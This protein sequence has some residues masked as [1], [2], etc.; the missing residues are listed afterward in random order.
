MNTTTYLYILVFPQK[1]VIK[2][3][4]ANDIQNRIDSLRRWWGEVNY[5]ASYYLSI[6]EKS[7]FK[8]EKSL[9]FL[10]SRYS[11]EFNDGDG[12]SEIFAHDALEKAIDVIDLYASLTQSSTRLQKGIP[13]PIKPQSDRKKKE[14]Y[15]KAAAKSDRFFNSISACADRFRKINKLIAF[16][17]RYQS[18]IQFQYDIVDDHILF[19]VRQNQARNHH[20]SLS[21]AS[22]FSFGV[23]DFDVR[24][25]MNC[26]SAVGVGDVVQYRIN[27][28]RQDADSFSH[29]YLV[30]LCSQ[31]ERMLAY[32]PKRSLATLD[33]IP[34]VDDA[35]VTSSIF[36]EWRDD[37]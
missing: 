1:N 9:H 22:L 31:A 11:V 6:E 29:P 8:L 37:R 5:P 4:K 35:G 12:K 15:E 16:L 14:K 34:I 33:E 3:G 30:Y 19:R 13:E 32:L 10:L 27:L 17:M 18:R 2:I 36:D 25:G 28:I 21:V 23:E 20:A 24:I 7:V 26:C